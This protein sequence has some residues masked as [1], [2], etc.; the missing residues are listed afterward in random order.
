MSNK[1]VR[2]ANSAGRVLRQHPLDKLLGSGLM[3]RLFPFFDKHR[4]RGELRGLSRGYCQTDFDTSLWLLHRGRRLI[5]SRS[6]ICRGFDKL[7]RRSPIGR[8]QERLIR[9]AVDR[10]IEGIGR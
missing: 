7:P 6:G 2:M 8:A 1:G 4:I 3:F 5:R 10:M 9:R